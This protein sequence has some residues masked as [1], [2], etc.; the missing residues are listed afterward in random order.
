MSE[1]VF[2]FS[3]CGTKIKREGADER[4]SSTNWNKC[5]EERG[6]RGERVTDECVNAASKRSW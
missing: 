1:R 4:V 3:S 5:V 2:F 6:G